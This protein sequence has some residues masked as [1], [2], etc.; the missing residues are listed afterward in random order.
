MKG[1]AAC[2]GVGGCGTLV[3]RE[4][5]MASK[6]ES[7]IKAREE[8]LQAHGT[9]EYPDL[10]WKVYNIEKGPAYLVERSPVPGANQWSWRCNCPWMVKRSRAF[11]GDAC[12][13]IVRVQDKLGS[14]DTG[15]ENPRGTQ[16]DSE[17]N[18][19]CL[20]CRVTDRFR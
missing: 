17:G 10:V 4:E 5:N 1:L 13:H 2:A 12:K 8:R 19:L 20:T 9:A 6:Q 3:V 11:S 15:C 14:C 7:R 18:S 16:I